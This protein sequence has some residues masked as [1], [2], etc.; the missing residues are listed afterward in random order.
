MIICGID[1]SLTSPAICIHSGEVWNANNCKF[2]YLT[3]KK[4][5][6]VISGQFFGF[7]YEKYDSDAHRYDNL[8]RWSF[9]IIEKNNVTK[10]FIEGYAYGAVGRVFNIAENT[11]LLKY[12]LWHSNIPFDVFAPSEIKKLASGKG[13][14]NKERLYECF[15]AETNI[16]IRKNLDIMNKNIWNPVSDIVDSY[17]IAK[18]GHHK[19]VD[20]SDNT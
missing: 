12:K 17:Y 3:P 14:A 5:W 2:Y 4:K 1:Y 10:C 13:N 16:D 8:S 7:E 15:I 20:K 11:G 6:L 19:M 9:D 18:L